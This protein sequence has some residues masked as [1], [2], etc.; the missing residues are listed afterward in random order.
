MLKGNTRDQGVKRENQGPGCLRG[1]AGTRE[2]SGNTWDKGV[3]RNT[4][5]QGV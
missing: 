2:F 5:K 1:I 4:R 3:R